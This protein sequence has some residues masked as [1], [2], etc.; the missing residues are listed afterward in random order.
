[1][2]NVSK[3]KNDI[4]YSSES[5]KLQIDHSDYSLNA[6]ASI[7]IEAYTDKKWIDSNDV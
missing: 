2:G 6:L 7:E 1:M 4:A 5:N 3:F